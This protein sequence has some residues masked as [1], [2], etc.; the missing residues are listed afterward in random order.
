MQTNNLYRPKFHYTS[1][2]GWINDPNGFSVFGG[3]YHLFAQHNPHDTKWGPMHWCHGVSED[4][5]AWEHKEIALTPNEEYEKD[6]GCFSGT[7][8]EDNGK[9]ILMYTACKGKMGEPVEQLQCIAIGDGN[10]YKKLPQ[11]PVI[12]GE[13]LP[14]FATSADFRDPKLFKI[15]DEY[16]ALLGAMVTSK[17]IGTMLL[18]K[19]KNLTDWEYVGETLRGQENGLMGIVFECPDLFKLGEKYVILTSPIEMPSQGDKYRNISSAVYF[20]GDMN[21][22][23]GK[24][25]ADYYDEIDTGFDFYAPQTLEDINGDRIL[26]AWAQM[27]ERNFVTDQLNHGWAGAMTL[28]RKLTLENKRLYQKPIET[29][30]KYHGKCYLDIT[31]GN[32]DCFRLQIESDLSE[33]QKFEIELLKTTSGSF[34]ISYDRIENKLIINRS[35]SLFKLDRHLKEDGVDNIRKV[36]LDSYISLKLDIIVDKS[37]VEIFINGGRYTMTSNYYCGNGKIENI[38][39]TDYKTSLKKYDLLV[40]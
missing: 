31:K 36:K 10:T 37:L 15:K 8:I 4:L 9:H 35:K 3:K 1:E 40:K 27:W 34:K 18:Y 19:S 11:N 39:D 17:K 20:V 13:D 32:P 25:T 21:F 24:F 26:I 6:L 33:G 38:I 16:F 5:I 22:E 23:T 12:T 28:P 7:A 30:E 29:L 2:S 14:K